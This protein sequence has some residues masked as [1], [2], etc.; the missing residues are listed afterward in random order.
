VFSA[1]RFNTAL[2]PVAPESW[3]TYYSNRLSPRMTSFIL[4]QV[5]HRVLGK[6]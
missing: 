4:G 1:V 5:A 6:S 2:R 3:L